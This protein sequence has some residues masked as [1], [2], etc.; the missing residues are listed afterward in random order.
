MVHYP[1]IDVGNLLCYE[2]DFRTQVVQF[3]LCGLTLYLPVL[4]ES[5]K[6]PL[7][8]LTRG[9]LALDDHSPATFCALPQHEFLEISN[10]RFLRI[11]FKV[12]FGI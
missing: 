10:Q 9:Y 12:R 1:K 4:C 2:N 8:R 5:C 11:I 7:L 3:I 6:E